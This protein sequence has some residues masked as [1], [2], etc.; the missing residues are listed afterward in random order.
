VES[1]ELDYVCYENV[2]SNRT[3]GHV[4]EYVA[5]KE[6]TYNMKG[7]ETGQV[8]ICLASDLI[9]QGEEEEELKE[10]SHVTVRI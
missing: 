4:F 9:E 6:S 1:G 2:S 5:D 8:S 7:G 10:G 3:K